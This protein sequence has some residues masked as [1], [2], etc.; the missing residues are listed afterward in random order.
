MTKAPSFSEGNWYVDVD[1][2][3]WADTGAEANSRNTAQYTACSARQLML[4]LTD[5]KLLSTLNH[6]KLDISRYDNISV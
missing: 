1:E 5:S 2:A 3:N 6:S 4:I